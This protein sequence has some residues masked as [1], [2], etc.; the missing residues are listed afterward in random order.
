MK[1]AF[2]ATIFDS[3]TTG[4]E[5]PVIVETAFLPVSLHTPVGEQTILPL[6]VG[7][8]ICDRWNPGKPIE[9]GAMAT[10]FIENEDVADCKPISMFKF[11]A[12]IDY[13][14][15]HNID[16]DWE[17][18]GQP[19]VKRVC[20]LAISRHL[21]PDTSH[22]LLALIYLLEPEAARSLGRDAHSAGADVQLNAILLK[23][24][25]LA[26]PELNSWESLWAYSEQ[27]R[28]PRVMPFGKHKG[29][30]L[31]ELPKD[32]VSWA[33]KNLKDMDSYLRGA[34]QAL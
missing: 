23:H 1:T 5:S 16:Y 13:L 12:S 4:M 20:T 22:K 6:P 29:V 15:G 19:E 18:A 27:C 2:E 7:T 17:A 8:P 10:H 34:L 28:V 33:L 31:A 14:I 21:W 26:K 9:F 11:P 32:Y 30:P 25:F 3:E 24:I